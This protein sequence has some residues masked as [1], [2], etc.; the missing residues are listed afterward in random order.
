MVKQKNK[1]IKKELEE[2]EK[3]FYGTGT[4]SSTDPEPDSDDEVSVMLEDAMGKD[5]SDALRK[6]EVNTKAEEIDEDEKAR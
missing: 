4:V 5:A 2:D 6:H 1:V 3:D